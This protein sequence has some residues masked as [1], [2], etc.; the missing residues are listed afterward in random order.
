MPRGSLPRYIVNFEELASMFP[1]E[2]DSTFNPDKAKQRCK[3]IHLDLNGK[4]SMMEQWEVPKD[5][6]L[7]GIKVACSREN[8][9]FMDNFDLSIEYSGEEQELFT[10]VYMKD[11][12]E[13]KH[14]VC[15]HKILAGSVIIIRYENKSESDKDVWFDIDY[16]AE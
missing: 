7:T 9:W 6:V 3:G 8:E 2:A 15:Y 14:F 10:S 11:F 5:I 16:V 12:M 1:F 4:K 13:Y